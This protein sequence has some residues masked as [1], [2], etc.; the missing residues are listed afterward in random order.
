MTDNHFDF[1]FEARFN[2]DADPAIIS[3]KIPLA[4]LQVLMANKEGAISI[5]QAEF[6]N[7]LSALSVD[8]QAPL[9]DRAVALDLLKRSI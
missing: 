4:E 5:S 2:F 8:I 7:T 1:V 6:V 9:H 3:F